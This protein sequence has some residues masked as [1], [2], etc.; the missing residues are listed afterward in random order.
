MS[1]AR[2]WHGD[3]ISSTSRSD[4]GASCA[5]SCR[6]HAADAK[7]NGRS[8]VCRN[9]VP[10]SF[11]SGASGT[12]YPGA[13][14][15]DEGGRPRCGVEICR[16]YAWLARG[17]TCLTRAASWD[18]GAASVIRSA[19]PPLRAVSKVSTP[20]DQAMMAVSGASL[21]SSNMLWRNCTTTAVVDPGRAS[22]GSISRKAAAP[23][24]MASCWVG[25]KPPAAQPP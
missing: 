12:A 9:M 22:A 3:R 21:S 1:R 7:M 17:A 16:A 6:S 13:M 24:R 8:H 15:A 18:H 2:A 14:P 11:P 19:E 4:G 20:E 10:R 25:A 5:R 23:C